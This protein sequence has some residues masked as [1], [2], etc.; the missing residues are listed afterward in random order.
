MT[1]TRSDTE[2]QRKTVSTF[3]ALADA[4]A[5]RS[6]DD[7]NT[8]SLC[9]GW[10]IRGERCVFRERETAAAVLSV[11]IVWFKQESVGIL[12][13]SKLIKNGQIVQNIKGAPLRSDDQ[14]LIAFVNRQIR[15]GDNR[16]I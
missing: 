2:I 16:Q 3:L 13:V 8:A 14:I 7:W 5:S 9:A 15:N 10:R 11:G 1:L 6:D 12:R 4:L